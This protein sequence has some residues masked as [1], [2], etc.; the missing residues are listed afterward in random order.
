MARSTGRTAGRVAARTPRPDR[1]PVAGRRRAAHHGGDLH[2]ARPHRDGVHPT[3]RRGAGRGPD[4]PPGPRHP[5]RSRAG[6]RRG[7]DR[8]DGLVPEAVEAAIAAA[9]A[10]GKRVSLL[11]AIATFGNPTG[12]TLS[13]GPASGSGA[14][15]RRERHRDR[16]GRRLSR[17]LVHGSA[18]AV[19][20]CAGRRRARPPDGLVLE[21]AGAGAAAGLD[22]RSRAARGA[23]R[24]R[25]GAGVGRGAE[26]AGRPDGRSTRPPARYEP[27]VR[28]FGTCTGRDATRSS[29][30][31]ARR[32][33]RRRSSP[34]GGY[35]VWLRLPGG[36]DSRAL[37]PQA[38]AA[39]MTYQP[40]S[41]FDAS[42]ALDPSWLRLSFARYPERT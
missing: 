1:R 30:R 3:R 35:F 6:A 36:L 12:R 4:L 37:L 24:R 7:R 42:G 29:A 33:R 15:R 22:H 39:G 31:S 20:R 38:D 26:P 18:S 34:E 32:C 21:V 25:R 28:D 40:G 19:D 13:L 5:A 23:G 17:T 2:G 16:R 11:Y 8:C 27:N 41:K 9:R 14:A 10:A